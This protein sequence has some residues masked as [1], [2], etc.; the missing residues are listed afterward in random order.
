MPTLQDWNNLKNILC[1]RIDNLGDVIMTTPAIRALKQAVPDRTITLMT[2]TAG[3]LIAP[4]IPELDDVLIFNPVWEKNNIND[5]PEAVTGIVKTLKEKKFD[6]AVIFTVYS[7]NPLPAAMICYMAGIPR[8]AGLCRENP[9]KLISD[10]MPDEEPLY[11]LKHEVTRQIDLVKSLGAPVNK[12]NFSL[13]LPEYAVA[14]A[15]EKLRS[16]GVD[17]YKPFIVIHPGVS[18]AKRQ[19][20]VTELAAACKRIVEELNLQ[21]IITGTE[22][23][24]HLGETIIS[25]VSEKVFN[26][27][28]AFSIGELMGLIKEAAFII[29]NNTGPVHIA[30]ALE[31]P[32]IVLYALTNPQHSPWNVKHILLPFA[33]PQEL[34]SKNTIIRLANEK[35]FSQEP[36]QITAEDILNA[37]RHLLYDAEL[38]EKTEVIYL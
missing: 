28:G 38:P 34:Q 13:H 15:F 9:Y 1:I 29:S 32:V 22:S 33:V 10:W 2:S 35:A 17:I 16:A 24:R 5:G 6:A 11:N 20:P 31:T 37:S 18:D 4:Y 8:V 12:E 23:E 21:V 25:V 30:A 3:S 14:E 19:F 7:Q 26:L 36:G 27:C